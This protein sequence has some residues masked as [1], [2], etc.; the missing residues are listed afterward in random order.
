MKTNIMNINN[1]ITTQKKG[2]GDIRYEQ[3]KIHDRQK[4]EYRFK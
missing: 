2:G 3:K 4:G 1:C